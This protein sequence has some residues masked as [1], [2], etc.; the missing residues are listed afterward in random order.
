MYSFTCFEFVYLTAEA[1]IAHTIEIIGREATRKVGDSGRGRA[2]HPIVALSSSAEC[3][4][5][6]RQKSLATRYRSQTAPPLPGFHDDGFKVDQ[7]APIM[8]F[9]N[10]R[11]VLVLPGDVQRAYGL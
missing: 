1:P 11:Y 5:L 8:K 2:K 10:A 7:L 9:H 6:C 4:K 3:K